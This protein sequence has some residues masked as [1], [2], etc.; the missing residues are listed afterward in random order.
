[1]TF[2]DAEAENRIRKL[3]NDGAT[4]SKIAALLGVSRST[5]CAK[6]RRMNLAS[7]LGPKI[8]RADFK[9]KVRSKMPISA[10]VVRPRKPMER[11]PLPAAEPV[12]D[13]VVS[14]ENLEP[15]HCRWIHGDV[16]GQKWGYCGQ[17]RMGPLPYCQEHQKRAYT[18]NYEALDAR[19]RASTN[20]KIARAKREAGE[21]V[22]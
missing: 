3:W 1:M 14:F 12:P 15:H 16:G 7:R 13:H 5:V 21:T 18:A 11:V 22:E 2:W 8:S 17:E 20:W 19:D 9:H 6:A 10:H 4:A